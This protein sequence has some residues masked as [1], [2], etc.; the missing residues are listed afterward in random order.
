M[1][2]KSEI[3]FVI[4][5]FSLLLIAFSTPNIQ[6]V[7]ANPVNIFSGC[8]T[9]F[10]WNRK[11]CVPNGSV[12]YGKPCSEDN[13]CDSQMSCQYEAYNDYRCKCT[14][15]YIW[16]QSRK[17]CFARDSR[18]KDEPCVN[19]TNCHPNFVC[20]QGLPE[21]SCQCDTS[22]NFAWTNF[23][24]VMEN[25]LPYF[26]YCLTDAVCNSEHNLVCDPTLFKCICPGATSWNTNACVIQDFGT[27]DDSCFVRENCN[28]SIGLDCD[29]GINTCYC[30]TGSTWTGSTCA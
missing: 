26:S 18:I 8:Q 9:G 1:N 24:C 4:L 2:N 30:P 20:D 11:E 21:P 5:A 29:F 3:A 28:T 12:K 22:N 7:K 10:S 17:E 19:N 14:N 6:Q 27:L 13:N 15:G 25:T 23:T 16:E